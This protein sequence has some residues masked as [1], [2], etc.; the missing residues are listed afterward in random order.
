MPFKGAIINQNAKHFAIVWTKYEELR[1]EVSRA[2][3]LTL[4]KPYFPDLPIILASEDG[5]DHLIYFGDANL[6]NWLE[7][8]KGLTIK[9][10]EYDI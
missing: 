3:Y 10:E 1:N 4:C 6:I 5:E 8:K 2:A 9:W 7:N